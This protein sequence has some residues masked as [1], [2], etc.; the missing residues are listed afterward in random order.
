MPGRLSLKVFDSALIHVGLIQ[1]IKSWYS[2][3]STRH[4]RRDDTYWT[5]ILKSIHKKA[6]SKPRCRNPAQQLNSEKANTVNNAFNKLYGDAVT[7]PRGERMNKRNEVAKSLVQAES[8]ADI[9]ALKQ[10]AKQEHERALKEWEL[11]LDSIEEAEDV[12]G[13]A[14][15]HFSS[16]SSP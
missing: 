7:M 8:E 4:T 13:Y 14:S 15:V 11:E 16:I 3:R 10:R 1:K 5:P 12:H 6:N 2:Y 9:K